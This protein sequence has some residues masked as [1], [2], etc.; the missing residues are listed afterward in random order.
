M[1]TF[2]R[3]RSV[4]FVWPVLL[5]FVLSGCGLLDGAQPDTCEG[6]G[7][8]FFD[9]FSGEKDCGWVDYEELGGSARVE[10]GYLQVTSRE[11]GQFWWSNPAQDFTNVVISVQARQVSGPDDNA[12][13]VMCRYQSPENFYMFLISGDGYYAIG[14]F[15]TGV[16]A[17]Q[18][19]TADGNYQ[20]SDV[21]NQGVGIN[22]VRASCVG[23]ELSLTVNGILL[24]TVNDPTFVKG[25]IGLGVTTFQPGT[26]VVQFDRL[27]VEAP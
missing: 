5:V 18:Y 21:I 9:D 27:R 25:D 7:F 14:K 12:Y 19:L 3:C 26:S 24:V 11:K 2:S 6:E 13:G 8:L 1:R 4:R 15:Q 16:D 22:E 20:Y 10:G 17:I 23:N